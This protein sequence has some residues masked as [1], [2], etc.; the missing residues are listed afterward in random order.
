MKEY[1]QNNKETI[2]PLSI[3]LVFF[4]ICLIASLGLNYYL[5]NFVSERLESIPLVLFLVLSVFMITKS[6]L[7]RLTVDNPGKVSLSKFE[8]IYEKYGYTIQLSGYVEHKEDKCAISYENDQD[9]DRVLGMSAFHLFNQYIKIPFVFDFTRDRVIIRSKKVVL[10][11]DKLS[12]DDLEEFNPNILN[13]LKLEYKLSLDKKKLIL[14]ISDGNKVD[15]RLNYKN[16]E[17]LK[18]EIRPSAF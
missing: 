3:K 13:F 14:A 12:E 16:I 15:M 8:E 5:T 2:K 17:N 4:T 10:D 11:L 9:K 7:K 6:E 18:R 1:Y